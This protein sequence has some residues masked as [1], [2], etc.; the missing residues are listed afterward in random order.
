MRGRVYRV[1]AI[2]SHHL[3]D[4]MGQ[5]VARA[6]VR[7]TRPS[8]VENHDSRRGSKAGKELRV[9]RPLPAEVDAISCRGDVDEVGV[10]FA[11]DLVRDAIIG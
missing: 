11:E 4:P 10:P 3:L 6:S 7:G 5:R 1:A 9:R 2:Q 8:K